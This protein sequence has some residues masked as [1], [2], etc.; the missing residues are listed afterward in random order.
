MEEE[1]DWSQISSSDQLTYI[2][3]RPHASGAVSEILENYG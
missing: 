3:A 1:T 2:N